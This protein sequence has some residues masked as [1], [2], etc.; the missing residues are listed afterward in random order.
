MRA[1]MRGTRDVIQTNQQVLYNSCQARHYCDG[2]LQCVLRM[3]LLTLTFNRTAFVKDF[4][5]LLND[6][7]DASLPLGKRLLIDL[8]LEN[9]IFLPQTHPFIDRFIQL[10]YPRISTEKKTRRERMTQRQTF[11]QK[12]HSMKLSSHGGLHKCF[13]LLLPSDL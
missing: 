3:S 11:S 9:R 6:K 10:H 1:T 5:Q 13:Q 12:S 2:W 4:L 8:F 7:N